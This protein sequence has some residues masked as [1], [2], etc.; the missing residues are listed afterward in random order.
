MNLMV[1]T[2]RACAAALLTAAITM[3]AVAGSAA[4]GTSLPVAAAFTT[5]S[6]SGGTTGGTS[7]TN[8]P[9][10]P[11]STAPTENLFRVA[12]HLSLRHKS[13]TTVV[14]VPPGLGITNRLEI[15]ILFGTQRITQNYNEISGNR[16][17]VDFDAL[18]GAARREN[19]TISLRDDTPTGPKTFALPWTVNLEPLFDLTIS[20]L[21]F[22]ALGVCD[23]LSAADPVIVWID[24]EGA[25]HR[26]KLDGDAGRISA[27]FAGTW[28]EVGVSSGLT[29]P[30]L[31]WFEQDRPVEFHLPPARGLPVLPGVSRHVRTVLD[32]GDCDGRFDY[33]VTLSLRRYPR[34]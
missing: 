33:D 20:P 24:P 10:G 29:I 26:V 31:N 28:P 17:A 19:V 15:S 4:K 34:L 32:G 22:I 13:V 21:G 25:V 9:A 6:P 7:G 2:R 8:A 11:F 18:E 16:L 27:G 5:G 1:I 12:S 3:V 30:G 14:T 23:P